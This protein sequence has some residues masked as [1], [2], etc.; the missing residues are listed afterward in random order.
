MYY[1]NFLMGLWNGYK[2]TWFDRKILMVL[3]CL[4]INTQ[5]CSMIWWMTVIIMNKDLGNSILKLCIKRKDLTCDISLKTHDETMLNCDS[6]QYQRYQP[7]FCDHST[8]LFLYK[9]FCN[10]YSNY[11]FDAKIL[12]VEKT[13]TLKRSNHEWMNKISKYSPFLRNSIHFHVIHVTRFWWIFIWRT[14][15]A[16]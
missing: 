11:I 12:K 14:W 5:I 6:Y 8:E 10:Y 1:V 2:G 16:N 3:V 4:N 9:D 15:S 13:H 7:S